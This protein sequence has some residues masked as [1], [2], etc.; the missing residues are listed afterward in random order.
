MSVQRHSYP[1]AGNLQRFELEHLP[2]RR[3]SDVQIATD[4]EISEIIGL[5]ATYL[6]NVSVDPSAVWAVHRKAKSILSVRGRNGL[7]GATAFLPLTAQGFEVFQSGQFSIESPDTSLLTRPGERAS[8]IYS[9]ALCVP[10]SAVASMGQVMDWMRRPSYAGCDIYACPGT[11]AG[12]RFMKKIGF[13]MLTQELNNTPLWIYRR[14]I[15]LVSA[16][17]R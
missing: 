13:E 11:P 9:W 1:T 10:G 15:A 5:T 16:V 3:W 14:P 4:E 17:K 7:I 6:P 12:E 8:A 2:V